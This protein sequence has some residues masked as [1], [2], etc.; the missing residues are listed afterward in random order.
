MNYEGI[1]ALGQQFKGENFKVLAFPV[2]QYFDQEPGTNAEIEK[3]VSGGGTHTYPGHPKATWSGTAVPPTLLFA[4]TSAFSGPVTNPPSWAP[5][6]KGSWCNSTSPTACTPSSADC[7]PKN[8]VVY[9]WL[10]RT[11]AGAVSTPS[12]PCG[13]RSY[14]PAWN[15]AGK[16]LVDKCGKLRHAAQNIPT[17][18]YSVIAPLVKQL[19][20]EEP[21]C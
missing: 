2:S 9:K 14:P 8:E 13:N 17:L 3:Y 10:A 7:C 12:G 18:P 5:G 19:L 16:Y 20:A 4:K 15:F 11:C 21:K 1:A 6:L